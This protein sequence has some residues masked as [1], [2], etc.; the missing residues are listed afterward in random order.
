[1]SGESPKLSPDEAEEPIIDPTLHTID[2]VVSS[3]ERKHRKSSRLHSKSQFF[4]SDNNSTN[5]TTTTTTSSSSTSTPFTESSTTLEKPRKHRHYHSKSHLR[6]QQQTTTDDIQSSSNNPSN[7]QSSPSSQPQPPLNSPS[8]DTQQQQQQQQQQQEAVDWA[9]QSRPTASSTS[10]SSNV[11]TNKPFW[12]ASCKTLTRRKWSNAVGKIRQGFTTP[13]VVSHQKEEEEEEEMISGNLNSV[14]SLLLF[15]D[16][17]AVQ[18]KETGDTALHIAAAHHQIEI[19]KCLIQFVSGGVPL[20]LTSPELSVP[21]DFDSSSSPPSSSSSVAASAFVSPQTPRPVP[22]STAVLSFVNAV[23]TSDGD[24]ALHIACRDGSMQ[25]T[26]LLM[27]CGA[28]LELP[29]KEGQTPL[30]VAC[31]GSSLPLIS[32]L[33]DHDAN[34]K[35]RDKRGRTAM[36]VSIPHNPW[37]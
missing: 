23:N 1:M 30:L 27:S 34:V 37:T 20:P 19:A 28:S 29:N 11:T 31:S 6:L 2:T 35:A 4:T 15:V 13:K 8:L 21:N 24:S 7:I 12:I 22:I 32:L 18:D 17:T 33:V 26:S 14:R 5:E 9:R 10:N 16:V 3:T 36:H 25:L